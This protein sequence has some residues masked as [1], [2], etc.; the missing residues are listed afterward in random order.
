MLTASLTSKGRISLPAKVRATLGV[1]PG[2]RIGFIELEKGLF[3]LVAMNVPVRQL[4]GSLTRTRQI[5]IDEMNPA[6]FARNY[7]SRTSS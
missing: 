4:R 3:F 2:D 7:F 6:K 1:E 5:S